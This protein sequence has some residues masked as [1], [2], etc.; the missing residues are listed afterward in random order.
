[1]KN[2]KAQTF[3]RIELDADSKF[4]RNERVMYHA[5][6][7]LNSQ[8]P[9]S[10]ICP[11][12]HGYQILNGLCIPIMHSKSPLLEELLKWVNHKLKADN[13]STEDDNDDY[14]SD[15]DESDDELSIWIKFHNTFVNSFFI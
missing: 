2:R 15:E 8:N 13:T 4:H 12:N 5:N 6:A 11:I 1:M 14:C 10:P 7:L 9:V 3:A